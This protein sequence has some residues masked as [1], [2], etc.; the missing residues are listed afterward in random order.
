M[1]AQTFFKE[2]IKIIAL[3]PKPASYI[4]NSENCNYGEHI[5]YSKNLFFS[6][7]CL[8]CSDSTYIYDSLVSTNSMDCDYAN[9]SDQCYES[10][11]IHKCS[12]SS[13]LENCADIQDSSY[14]TS[15][16]DCHD[17]FGCVLLRNKSF[18]IFNRQFSETEYH[19]QLEKYKKWPLEKILLTI[20]E[21]K[22][23]YPITQ[24]NELHNENS[25]YG[26]YVYY[27]KD[28]YICFDT[29]YSFDCGYNFNSSN[30][31]NS[32]DLTYSTENESC[33]EMINSGKNINSSY[34]AYSANC[35]NSNYLIN[36]FGLKDS[37]GCFGLSHKQYCIL[38]RQFTK[39]E[40]EKISQPLLEE[41]RIKNLD[42]SDIIY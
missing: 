26:N 33:Y 15:C 9:E 41:L 19:Q 12:N 29:S 11:D 6:F 16:V 18:C 23:Q 35:K 36:C 39:E 38:N 8:N 17:V 31:K 27:S 32:Y 28:C 40:Y 20:E 1:K 5:Y 24:T 25:N 14:S 4:L 13:F 42:W 7:D 21:L 2:I 10:V 37:L 34:L 3:G 30:N 22:K